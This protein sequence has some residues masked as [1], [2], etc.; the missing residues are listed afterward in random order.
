MDLDEAMARIET[1]E[2]ELDWH[3]QT[4]HRAH[5]DGPLD[6]CQKDT[7]DAVLKSLGKRASTTETVVEFTERCEVVEL[8]G[9]DEE[10]TVRVVPRFEVPLERKIRIPREF[11]KKLAMADVLYRDIDVTVRVDKVKVEDD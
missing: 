5:H 11:L 1:L 6:E 7:C 2:R 4:V 9:E 10:F 8:D 3:R